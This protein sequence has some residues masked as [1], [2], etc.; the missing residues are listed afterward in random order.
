METIAT[1][2]RQLGL[3][4]R[5]LADR[6]GVKSVSTVAGWEQAKH[7]PTAR[8]LIALAR[9]FGVC[10]ERIVLPFDAKPPAPPPAE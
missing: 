5:E 4:Q 9:V 2:R 8:Q 10:C 3:S 7:E 1:Y 6:V